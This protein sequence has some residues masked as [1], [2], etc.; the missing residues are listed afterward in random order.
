MHNFIHIH[1]P[2]NGGSSIEKT[3]EDY[4][5]ENNTY[6]NGETLREDSTYRQLKLN[7]GKLLNNYHVFSIIRNP[8][9]R[10]LSIWQYNIKR[11]HGIIKSDVKD[12]L[13]KTWAKQS[14]IFDFN[15]FCKQYFAIGFPRSLT[16]HYEIPQFHYLRDFDFKLPENL[17]LL[18]LERIET[19]IEILSKLSGIQLQVYNVN[20][21]SYKKNPIEYYNQ[22]SVE[23]VQAIF[24]DDFE[25][26]GYSRNLDDLHKPPTLNQGIS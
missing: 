7:F 14:L 9:M 6:L 16:T 12:G 2:K 4:N 22:E 10:A 13:A 21:S 25:M 8:Y 3:L 24:H 20:K 26:L 15:D 5:L 11:N 19:D 1:I 23:T 18:S 17:Y